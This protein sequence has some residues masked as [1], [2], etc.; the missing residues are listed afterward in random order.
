[1]DTTQDG[2]VKKQLTRAELAKKIKDALLLCEILKARAE[3]RA[4][5]MI[6]PVTPIVG[7]ADCYH[8]QSRSRDHILHRVEVDADGFVCSCERMMARN[9]PDCWH[10]EQVRIYRSLHEATQEK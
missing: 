10:C 1:M 2:K 3:V 5:L 7:E 4:K 9:E 6:T 8:V